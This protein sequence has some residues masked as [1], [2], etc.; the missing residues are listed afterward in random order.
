MGCRHYFAVIL[1]EV[2]GLLDPPPVSN[3]DNDYWIYIVSN[4]TRS[5]LYIGL[6]SELRVRVWQ[7]RVADKPGSFSERYH[8][9]HLVYYEHYREVRDAIA[10]EKQLEG[11]RREKKN[12]LI[13][14]LNPHWD[15]LAADWF[16][17]WA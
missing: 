15:D 11:W 7:H 8:C 16:D 4:N 1:S 12:A 2:E 10:R 9:V 3:A 6:T 5:T 14:T 13:A 17:P